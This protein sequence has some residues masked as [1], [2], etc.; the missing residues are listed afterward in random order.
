[1]KNLEQVRAANALTA[2]R[3]GGFAGKNRGEVVKKVPTMIRE[4]GIL[5]ALAFAVER[6]DRN[7][8]KNEGHYEVFKAIVVHLGKDKDPDAFL[9]RL[10]K[11]DAAALRADT[12]E[13]LAYLAYLRRFAD[14]E[15]RKS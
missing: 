2:A 3:S 6:N 10:T 14:K 12:T 7:Q 5:G 1:M 13:A 11:T 4:N 9:D 15:G 8:L